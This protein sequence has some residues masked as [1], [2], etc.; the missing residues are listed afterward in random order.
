MPSEEERSHKK[1]SVF[2]VSRVTLWKPDKEGESCSSLQRARRSRINVQSKV[3]QVK[4]FFTETS[5]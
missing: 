3:L 5:I 2:V 1:E 4:L